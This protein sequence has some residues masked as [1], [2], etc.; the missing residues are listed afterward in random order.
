MIAWKNKTLIRIVLNDSLSSVPIDERNKVINAVID[1]VYDL[2]DEE[3]TTFVKF[4]TMMFFKEN[5]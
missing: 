1:N 2:L 5:T 3:L 4:L